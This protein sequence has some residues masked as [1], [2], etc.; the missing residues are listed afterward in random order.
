[1]G[2]NGELLKDRKLCSDM[3]NLPYPFEPEFSL[4]QSHFPLDNEGKYSILL[5]QKGL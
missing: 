4:E 3:V 2:I 5:S 1:M